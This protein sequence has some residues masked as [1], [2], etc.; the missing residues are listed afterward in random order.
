MRLFF[1]NAYL[2]VPKEKR[3]NLD[4]KL[5]KCIYFRYKDGLKGCK[6]LNLETR[7]VEYSQD[8]VFREV[9]YVIK[10]KSYRRNLRK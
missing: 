7:K 8:V 9:K 10:M 5:E 6:F 1:S 3:T 2:H 4:S